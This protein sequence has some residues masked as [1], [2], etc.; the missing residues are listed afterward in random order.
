[1]VERF[2]RGIGSGD[3]GDII[4]G[5]AYVFHFSAS[6]MERMTL[7]RLAFWWEKARQ[8]KNAERDALKSGSEV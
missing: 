1:M 2:F 8:I 6:D 4:A 5:V 7:R 3:I